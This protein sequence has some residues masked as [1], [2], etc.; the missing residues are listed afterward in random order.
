VIDRWLADFTAHRVPLRLFART[1]TLGETLEAYRQRVAQ[2]ARPPSA[3]Y[4]LAAAAGR[5]W[6]P[7]DQVSYYVTGRS[8]RVM[9]N[10][11]ARLARE[12]DSGHPD[13]NTAY[14]HAKVLETWE[15]F[16]RYTERDGLLDY[17]E[18]PE[19]EP[20]QLTLF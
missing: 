16:R 17:A 1:E 13:E 5:A 14:Y 3:A 11:A 6:Q 12:W 4:E 19:A 15:R 7:G 20:A 2:G 10:E 18:E 9:V 8:A